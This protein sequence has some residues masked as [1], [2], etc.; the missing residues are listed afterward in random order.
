MFV[1]FVLLA[2]SRQ[3]WLQIF[4]LLG[5]GSLLSRDWKH[6]AT[7][8]DCQHDDRDTVVNSP[9]VE[10]L[11]QINHHVTDRS[12]PAVVDD[13]IRFVGKQQVL[14]LGPQEHLKLVLNQTVS[15]D[16][17][18]RRLQL[19]TDV[20]AFGILFVSRDDCW[21]HRRKRLASKLIS[22]RKNQCCKELDVDTSIPDRTSPFF[23]GAFLCVLNK[24]R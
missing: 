17:E 3:L 16:F 13:R 4:H 15:G 1:V 24:C 6:H 9:T 19:Q 22:R 7:H 5:T 20:A 18:F 23:D 14:A 2:Q 21:S 10:R 11:Q 8:E 12:K